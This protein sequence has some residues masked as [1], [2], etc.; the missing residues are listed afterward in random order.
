MQFDDI[1]SFTPVTKTR[2]HPYR[3]GLFVSLVSLVKNNTR[4]NVAHRVKKYW[5]SLP[6]DIVDFRLYF[7]SF[8]TDNY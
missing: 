4:K 7:K 6:V 3:L 5:N 1:F 2:G 8:P